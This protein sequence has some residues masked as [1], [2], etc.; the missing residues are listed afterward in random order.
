[1]KRLRTFIVVAM[2]LFVLG[3]PQVGYCQRVI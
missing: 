1:M 3:L 2:A